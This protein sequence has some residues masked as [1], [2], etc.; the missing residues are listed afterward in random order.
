MKTKFICLS[1]A[2]ISTFGCTQKSK[3]IEPNFY[4]NLYT[5]KILDAL[6][7]NKFQ[8][9]LATGFLDTTYM[10]SL[11]STAM[12]KYVDSTLSKVNIHFFF[13]SR[14]VN[15]D[16]VIQ[17]FN[18]D[19]RIGDEY[20]VRANSYEKIGMDISPRIFQTIAGD[21]I[22]IGGKQD[23]PT[24]VNLWF[25]ECRGCIAEIPALNRLREKY[26]DKVNFVAMTFENKRSVLSFLK[27]KEFNCKHI[28]TANDYIKQ[29]AAKPYPEN[30]FI[31]RDGHIKY[32]EGAK[33]T[34]TN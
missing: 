28:T 23:K 9:S 6:E 2:I 22:Q 30:I 1:I 13:D 17:P 4:K 11:D 34:D 24:L 27:K 31:G 14:I 16:S 29:I 10:R 15:N 32:I 18:Y 25:V 33:E 19:I 21:S 7:F 5:G 3:R 12:K 26:V 20:I 8:N